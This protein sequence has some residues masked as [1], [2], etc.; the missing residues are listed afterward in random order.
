[1]GVGGDEGWRWAWFL[2]GVP[3]SIV[4][5]FAF[6]LKEPQ[7]GH[8]EKDHVLGEPLADDG[9]PVAISTEAAFARIRSIRT[10]RG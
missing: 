1:M 4:A 8:Y 2:L 10:I 7:R 9:Q 3:V 6:F 5:V